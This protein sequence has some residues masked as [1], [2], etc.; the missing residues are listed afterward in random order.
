MDMQHR[1]IL[2]QRKVV[3]FLALY[4][5]LTAKYHNNRNHQILSGRLTAS[6]DRT[7]P[8]IWF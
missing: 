5:P 7:V 2:M 4:N 8:E 6:L 1:N 3:L